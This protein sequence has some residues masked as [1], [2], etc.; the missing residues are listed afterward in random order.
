MISAPAVA[1]AETDS[2]GTAGGPRQLLL[3]SYLVL[4]YGSV[5]RWVEGGG[6]SCHLLVGGGVLRKNDYYYLSVLWVR[7]GAQRPVVPL[8]SLGE[9]SMSGRSA[10]H[11]HAFDLSN[12]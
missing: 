10:G 2:R 5:F 6:T 9:K 7:K 8:F 3:Y 4:T 11:G 12:H 1:S